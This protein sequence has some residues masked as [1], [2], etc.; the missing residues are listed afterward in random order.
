M[1]FGCQIG[2]AHPGWWYAFKSDFSGLARK[3]CPA[4]HARYQGNACSDGAHDRIRGDEP[5]EILMVS[6]PWPQHPVL[7]VVAISKRDSIDSRTPPEFTEGNLNLSSPQQN[8]HP[9]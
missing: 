4:D 2:I 1:P 6:H 7:A 5:A 3:L 8:V 9:D